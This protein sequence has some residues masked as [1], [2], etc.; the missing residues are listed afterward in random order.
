VQTPKAAGAV[1]PAPLLFL[2]G[3]IL[4]V[5]INFFLPA[6]IWPGI[7][8]QLL[9]ALVLVLATW[10]TVSALRTLARHKTSP[11]P[12]K[13]TAEL[14]QDG[15]YSFSRNPIYLSFA[16]MYLGFSCVFNSLFALIVFIPV[17]IVV[18]RTQMQR[19]E[20]YLE[21]VFDEEYRR[22]KSRVRRWI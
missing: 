6:L 8:V 4:G 21:T 15:P 7:W 16:L 14:V 10:L 5:V 3:L 2:S 22:Y 11:E 19:E 20:R 9:G 1:V 12:W 17:L 13:P 18:D